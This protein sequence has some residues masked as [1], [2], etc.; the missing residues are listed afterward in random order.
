MVRETFS[1]RQESLSTGEWA[2]AQKALQPCLRIITT[3]HWLILPWMH[4]LYANG[5]YHNATATFITHHI[6]LEGEGLLAL[7]NKFAEH[8]ALEVVEG[9]RMS[10]FEAGLLGKNSTKPDYKVSKILIEPRN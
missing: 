4:F 1:P 5:N 9:D 2:T 3:N 8:R 10:H 7:L 6:I